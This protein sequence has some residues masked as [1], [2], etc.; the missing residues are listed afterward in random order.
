TEDSGDEAGDDG[1]DQPR[2]RTHPGADTEGQGEGEGDDTD[3]DAGGDVPAPGGAQEHIIIGGGEEG[4]PLPALGPGVATAPAG[5]GRCGCGVGS[6]GC[7]V[8]DGHAVVTP[9]TCAPS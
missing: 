8:G 5:L 9:G 1:G 2:L 3:G 6:R 7:G 4:T